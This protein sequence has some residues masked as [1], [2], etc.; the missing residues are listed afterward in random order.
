MA[1]LYSDHYNSTISS[2]TQED[3]R[4]LIAAGLNHGKLRYKRA[5]V[6]TTL[7]TAAADVLRFF[8]LKSGD[9]PLEMLLS[10]TADAST[11]ATADIGIHATD[12]GA[13]IDI[14][15]WCA[16]GTA[17]GSDITATVSRLDLFTLG[18]STLEDR[19]KR[20]WELADIGA[21]TYTV[22]PNETWDMTMTIKAETGIV[23]T[24]YV[25]ECI[26]VPGTS[27]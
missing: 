17:P 6:T 25:L 26:Y 2:A 24:E 1:D 23:V 10:H 21:A 4:V 12:G 20:L 22:D 27:A 19:G 7:A 13:V 8:Q 16:F 5:T 9:R 14:A 15:L 11:S 18:D 3:P